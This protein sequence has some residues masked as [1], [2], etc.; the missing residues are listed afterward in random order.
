MAYLEGLGY[1]LTGALAGLAAGLLGVGGGAIMVPALVLLFGQFFSSASDWIPH[2][3]VATS[4]ATVIGTGAVATLAHARHGAVRWDY[5]G[6][7]AP[8]M[9]LG[10]WLGALAAAIV[11][12][13]WLVRL[14][15]VFL[16]YTG[17][18][19]WARAKPSRAQGLAAKGLSLPAAGAGIGGASAML[20]I[21]GGSMTVPFLVR[22][23]LTM[24]AAVATS[25]ACGVPIAVF[26]V[27]GFV[28]SG[29]G[30]EDL[31]AHSLGFV[32]WP[33]VLML[34]AGSLPLAPVGA[35]LAHRLP[36]LVLRRIFGTML[37]LISFRLLLGGQ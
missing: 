18:R 11:P 15:G 28:W 16:L 33:A 35:F 12:A 6:R 7:L 25:S 21:G 1:L 23:G 24:R 5:F 8:G 36:T 9:V 22:S 17:L 13:L 31:P 27:L 10:A 3:A 4:L 34:L 32:Y 14:F 26:G 20:G 30:R 2:Q 37:V 19:M 29:L